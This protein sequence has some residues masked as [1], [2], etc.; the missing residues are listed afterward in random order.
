[1]ASLDKAMGTMDLPAQAQ[2]K[3][4]SPGAN[5]AAPGRPMTEEVK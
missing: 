5:G 4:N 3:G 2:G 1:V